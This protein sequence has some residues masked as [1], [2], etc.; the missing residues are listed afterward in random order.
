MPHITIQA[1]IPSGIPVTFLSTSTRKPLNYKVLRMLKHQGVIRF[2][3][4][5]G[6]QSQKLPSLYALF[7]GFPHLQSRE[8]YFNKH[9]APIVNE[10]CLLDTTINICVKGVARRIDRNILE[11]RAKQLE[12]DVDGTSFGAL[13]ADERQRSASRTRRLIPWET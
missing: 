7:A 4:D 2:P 13:R 11:E 8:A 3:V 6:D 12:R 1:S 5:I 9:K 10:S